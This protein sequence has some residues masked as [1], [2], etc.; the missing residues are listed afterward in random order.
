MTKI[1]KTAFFYPTQDEN[2]SSAS[3]TDQANETIMKKERQNNALINMTEGNIQKEGFAT[4]NQIDNIHYHQEKTE[5]MS[6]SDFQDAVQPK[7]A[8]KQYPF[9][10]RLGNS[11]TK[12]Q[13]IVKYE[14]KTGINTGPFNIYVQKE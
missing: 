11:S 3:P 5:Y 9:T 7:G 13:G 6:Y 14:N 10:H 1:K 2:A 12:A 8:S 4:I